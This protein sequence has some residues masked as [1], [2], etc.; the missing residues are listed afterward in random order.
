MRARHTIKQP[1]SVSP[2][3]TG[4]LSVRQSH[5]GF[6]PELRK[7]ASARQRRHRLVAPVGVLDWRCQGRLVGGAGGPGLS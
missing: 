2:T 3:P 1:D 5:P 6:Q 4:N 7:A